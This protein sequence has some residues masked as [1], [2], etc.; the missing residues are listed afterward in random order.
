MLNIYVKHLQDYSGSLTEQ[1]ENLLLFFNLLSKSSAFAHKAHKELQ[2]L[3]TKE[4]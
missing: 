1:K 3:N 4:K 2:R